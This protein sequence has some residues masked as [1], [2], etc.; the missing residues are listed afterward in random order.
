MKYLFINPITIWFRWYF[1][2]KKLQYKERGKNLKIGYLS[3]LTNVIVGNFNTLY[4]NLTI[5][6]ST[7]DDFVYVGSNTRINNANIGKFCSIGPDVRIG[8]GKHPTH[9]ISTFPAFFSAQKQCQIA[10]ADKNYFEE[11]LPIII[12]NDV[13]IGANALIMDGIKIGNGAIIAAGAVVTKNVEPFTIVGGVP[14]KLIK[15]RFTPEEITKLQDFKWWDNDP[16]WLKNNFES[17][18]LPDH[19]FKTT[20]KDK[21]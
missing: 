15:K 4:D 8:L 13:W 3:K 16:L 20:I 11:T 17:F 7:I 18:N 12:G 21:N 19:F 2:T 9:L 1:Q 6:N 5:I 10:F 14:A